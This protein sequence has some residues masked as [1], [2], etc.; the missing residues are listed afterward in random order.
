MNFQTN[1]GQIVIN[2]LLKKVKKHPHSQQVAADH[3]VLHWRN[4]WT[5]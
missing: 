3:E 5:G 4:C 2:R 1:G